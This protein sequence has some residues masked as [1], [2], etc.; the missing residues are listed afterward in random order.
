MP[1]PRVRFSRVHHRAWYDLAASWKVG[2]EGVETAARGLME[3]ACDGCRSKC[4]W[5]AV[6]LDRLEWLGAACGLEG[7]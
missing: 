6:G 5:S 2:V 4:A 1:Q 7:G 3:A